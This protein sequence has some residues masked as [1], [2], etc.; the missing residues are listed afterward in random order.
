MGE[1]RAKIE[2]IGYNKSRYLDALLDSGAYRNYIKKEF[3]DGRSIQDIGYHTINEDFYVTLADGTEKKAIRARV[4][5]LKIDEAIY[6]EPEIIIVD[7]LSDADIILGYLIMQELD[8]VLFPD[9]ERYEV[10][11][12]KPAARLIKLH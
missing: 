6:Q 11:R 7:N 2:L 8:I 10:R 3:N 1:I 5:G 4:K 12:A 9:E